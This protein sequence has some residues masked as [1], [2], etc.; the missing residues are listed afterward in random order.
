[1]NGNVA[2]A[3]YLAL[4]FRSTPFMRLLEGLSHG[5]STKTRIPPD[6]FERQQIPLPPLP[7]QRK[8]VAAW[9]A[10]WKYAGD[11]ATKVERLGR[12]IEAQFLADLGLKAPE[13]AT[14]PKAFA[15][16]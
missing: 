12:E 15:V 1:I 6:E 13:Q 2:D 11:A 8:I 16:R 10:A 14:P 7:V 4:V 5:G 9:E 3:A